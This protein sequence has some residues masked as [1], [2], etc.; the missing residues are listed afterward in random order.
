MTAANPA[1]VPS[2]A[3]GASANFGFNAT[4][5]G[6]NPAPTAFALNG[7]TCTGAAPSPHRR[8]DQPGDD[9]HDH[10]AA[11]EHDHHVAAA[12]VDDDDDQAPPAGPSTPPSSYPIPGRV[13]GDT[14]VH[15]PTIVKATDGSYLVVHTGNNLPIKTSTDRVELPQRGRGLARTVHRGRP[16]TPPA[17]GHLWAPDISYRNGQYYLYYT[18]STFGSRALGHLPRDQPER[19]R[20]ARGPIRA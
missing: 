1:W 4:W 12:D 17:A 13:T 5:N 7:T 6:Q 16:R 19:P 18:A 3:T 20:P 8:H 15:D 10:P 14:L 2:L 9:H 11:G